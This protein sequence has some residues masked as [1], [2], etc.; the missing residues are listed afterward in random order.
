MASWTTSAGAAVGSDAFVD[1]PATA[2]TAGAP[3]KEFIWSAVS[4]ATAAFVTFTVRT[5]VGGTTGNTFRVE[6]PRIADVGSNYSLNGPTNGSGNYNFDGTPDA[7]D[8]PKDF[9][10][11]LSI[12]NTESSNSTIQWSYLVLEGSVNGFT[13]SSGAQTLT[14][15]SLGTFTLSTLETSDAKIRIT[16]NLGGSTATIDLT[17]TKITLDPPPGSG[18]TPITQDSGFTQIS[19]PWTTFVAITATGLQIQVPTGK[20]SVQ[21]T[22]LLSPKWSVRTQQSLGPWNIEYKLQRENTPGGGT[23]TDV[24]SVQNSSPDPYIQA[25]EVFI[26]DSPDVRYTSYSGTMSATINDTGRTAGV[27]YSYRIVARISSGSTTGNTSGIAFTAPVGG[28]VTLS[29]P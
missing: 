5:L 1:V 26:D 11:T 22:V 27:T 16:A 14:N 9:N 21:C 4:P 6:A 19:S 8:L 15:G 7:G 18:G 13:V 24:G 20:T 12:N 10:Y 17:L 25:K 2:L 23:W 29:C 28:G 3:P